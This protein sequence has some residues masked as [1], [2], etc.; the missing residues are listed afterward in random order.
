MQD[1]EFVGSPRSD[2]VVVRRVLWGALAAGAVFSL[3]R[4][5]FS[6]GGV[7]V[8]ALTLG[9]FALLDWAFIRRQ[10]A[11]RR[12]ALIGPDGIQSPLFSTRVKQFAWDEIAGA[13]LV[14][15]RGIR[16]LQ[17]QLR[18][19]P[20]LRDKRAFWTG[21]NHARPQIPL[22]SL[23]AGEQEHLVLLVLERIGVAQP[24]DALP[25]PVR[26][27]R[28]ERV[29]QEQ[30]KAMAPIAWLTW[31]LVGANVAAW[32]LMAAAGANG[33]QADTRQLLDWGG[34]S[35]HDVVAR[36]QWWRLLSSTFLHDGLV[37]L[38]MNMVGL[39]STGPLVERLYGRRQFAL[40]YFG[41]ALAGSALSL[42]FAAERAVS[43]GA[44]GAVFGVFG[45]MLAGVHGHRKDLPR[46]FT[47]RTLGGLAFFV[48]YSL[49][50]G[51]AREGIDNAAHV[52]GLMTG[53]GLAWLL[54]RQLDAERYR[55]RFARRATVGLVLTAAIVGGLA[56]TAA[57]GRDQRAFFASIAAL[58]EGFVLVDAA[59]RAVLRD[60]AAMK[61][62]QITELALDEMSRTVHAP[63]YR[64][65]RETLERVRLPADD[66]RARLAADTLR[67]TQLLE[68]MLGMPSDIVDGK[69]VPADPA[70][71]EAGQ[72][73]VLELAPRIKAEVER[74]KKPV[75]RR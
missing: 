67:T 37:H 46:A 19:R 75:A 47:R 35:A 68:E 7:V 26:D 58:Q 8:A 51:F 45:A 62:G 72:K 29:F 25:D 17:L 42:H 49:L 28:Q 20:G 38:A 10:A 74:L 53:V 71:F 50:Q 36:G 30:L 61:Q 6:I 41:A 64:K 18:P 22:A 14:V 32:L 65:A 4:S 73:E 13:S 52:G 34:N 21:I 24:G 11:G 60:Q 55:T 16:T 31:T 69:P 59:N 54:P 63:M 9:F 27:L 3:V 12:V 39:A 48:A 40:V 15:P 70:R 33:L 5:G 43:V 1:I 66:P 56:G 2:A 44:S 23:E 57:P